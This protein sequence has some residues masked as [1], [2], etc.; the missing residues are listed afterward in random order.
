[1]PQGPSGTGTLAGRF[2]YTGQMWLPELGLY[3]YRARMYN[4]DPARGGHRFMQTDP[5]GYGDGPNLYVYVGG[6]PVNGTDPTGL[7]ATSTTYRNVSYEYYD[8]N[9]NR[10]HDGR[11]PRIPGSEIETFFDVCSGEYPSYSDGGEII[12]TGARSRD[13]RKSTNS[14]LVLLSVPYVGTSFCENPTVGKAN[15][16]NPLGRINS[17]RVGGF[18]RALRDIDSLARVNGIRPLGDQPGALVTT[19]IMTHFL[20]P[21]PVGGGWFLSLNFWTGYSSF[22]NRGFG[23]RYNPETGRI[24]VDIPGGALLPQGGVLAQNETCHYNRR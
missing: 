10:R 9:N 13:S 23:F 21:S 14:L 3:Y 22:T 8:H 1:M 7:C 16:F 20:I 4:P 15:R 18:D 2:G 17:G 19:G 24:R 11:E 5:I 12:V 6:D